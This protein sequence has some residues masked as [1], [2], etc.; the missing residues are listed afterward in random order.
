MNYHQRVGVSVYA[1]MLATMTACGT[2]NRSLSPPD[3]DPTII[4]AA[5]IVRSSD[6]NV[7]EVLKHRVRRYTYAEDRSGR[8]V[9][10]TTQRGASSLSLADANT[11]MIIIDG[12]RLT[13][14]RGLADV[15]ASAIASIEIFSGIRGT[16]IQGTNASAG[17][18]Y[19]H[20]HNASD[21]Q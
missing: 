19:I 12:A 1:A 16:G 8:P 7:W 2:T 17:V 14:V 10:I 6:V 20:T 21:P 9:Q 15:P 18:I 4:T 13:D 3:D 11:P 5:D